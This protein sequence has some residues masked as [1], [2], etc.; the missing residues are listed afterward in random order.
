M[1]TSAWRRSSDPALEPYRG[2]N[3]Q[4]GHLVA[5]LGSADR[6]LGMLAG[7]LGEWELAEGHFEIACEVN[8]ALGARTWLG[9]TLVEH[10][11]VLLAR[12][13]GDDRER[14]SVLL[15]RALALAEDTGLEAV[16]ARAAALGGD[17]SPARLPPDGLSAREV[18]ILGLVA[19]GLSNR[20]IGARLHI[21]EHTAANHIRSILR[22][23][24]CAN[25]TEAA[26][27]AHRHR[28]VAS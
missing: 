27:Y 24:G 15:G 21:S 9:H 6:F 22:K 1:G 7:C 16:R 28:L 19:L 10:A 17:A 25:R 4:I 12:R 18:E 8:A 13:T 5:C 26:T 20:D 14:A 23:T 2:S 11:R 3:V